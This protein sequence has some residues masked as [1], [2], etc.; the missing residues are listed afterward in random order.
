[1]MRQDPP[2]RAREYAAVFLIFTLMVVAQ[3]WW[4]R[5]FHVEL[6][7]S[8][9]ESSHYLSGLMIHDYLRAGLPWPPMAYAQDY[10]AHYP[11]VALGH[12]PPVYF[13]LQTLWAL[14]FGTAKASALFF[15][16]VLS[17]LFLVA[18][19]ALLRR[20][21]EAWLSALACLFALTMPEVAALSR[22]LGSELL[23]S[24]LVLAA[25]LFLER[26]LQ[27][28][29]L[30]PAVGFGGSALLAVLTKGTAIMLIPLAAVL[31]TVYR[32]W[33]LLLRNR[34]LWCTVTMAAVLA[35]PWYLLAPD[36]LH[37]RVRRFGGPGL[38]FW[39]GRIDGTLGFWPEQL[40]WVGLLLVAAGMFAFLFLRRYQHLRPF[41]YLAL[42][43]LAV[44]PLFR[45]TILVW[46][47]RHFVAMVPFVLIFLSL[48]IL[49][50]V[51]LLGGGIP[52]RAAGALL[53]VVPALW[54]VRSL[55][56]KPEIGLASVVR[57][58]AAWPPSAGPLLIVAGSIGEGAFVSEFA[59]I[60]HR[61]GHRIER[62][63]KLFIKS[64][65]MA[66]HVVKRYQSPAELAQMLSDLPHRAIVLEDGFEPGHY[67]T[68]IRGA[69]A[70]PS[71]GWRIE[72]EFPR[73][74]R[75]TERQRFLVWTR[76]PRSATVT[77]TAHVH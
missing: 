75:E 22:T 13:L 40:G 14:P 48:G 47:V 30:W 32:G 5:A 53:L 38:Y 56:P 58:L 61:P 26:F 18:T 27:R 6:T 60:D 76:A 21:F 28:P 51:R 35:V 77:P 46:E 8:P 33:L 66:K 37:E 52:A 63:S 9:D 24:G 3:A 50:L 29:G 62:G 1:M 12:W 39:K 11:K 49:E 55:P 19:Y 2:V 65:F 10:Y 67:V 72:R 73:P 43:A 54:H 36:A 69:L 7:G 23:L 16:C 34:A 44:I 15:H 74:G 17:A 68:E 71:S 70:A 31:T 25:L 64:D 42:S 20:W 57:H 59:M 45:F 41:G 4:G